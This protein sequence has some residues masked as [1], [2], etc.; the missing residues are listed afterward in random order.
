MICG[1][2]ADGAN[3]EEWLAFAGQ[4]IWSTRCNRVDEVG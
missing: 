2:D 1:C 3:G 4:V